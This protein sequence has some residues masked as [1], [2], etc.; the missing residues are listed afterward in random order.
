MSHDVAGG[1]SRKLITRILEQLFVFAVCIGIPS[2]V[3]AVAPVSWVKLH[4]RDGRVEATSKSCI[5]YVIPFRFRAI[6]EVTEVDDR[7]V[8]GKLQRKSVSG[9]HRY[10]KSEDQGFL[11]LRG[12]GRVVEVPTSPVDLDA[13]VQQIQAFLDDPAAT[14][15]SMFNVANWKFS[16]LFGGLASCLTV[17]YVGCLLFGGAL[18]MI[19]LVQRSFGVPPQDRFLVRQLTRL[20]SWRPNALRR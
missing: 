14:E 13:K 4:R 1:A 6:D 2:I 7:V 16:I 9:S 18:K 8:A 20:E 19:R 10:T 12:P 15:L 17:L 5:L 3:T 11:I